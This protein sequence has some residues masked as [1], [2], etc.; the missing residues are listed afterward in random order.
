RFRATVDRYGVSS[1]VILTDGQRAVVQGTDEGFKLLD[2]TAKKP[3]PLTIGST[4]PGVIAAMGDGASAATVD[5]DLQV[6]LWN[7]ERGEVEHTLG[8]HQDDG[9][10]DTLAVSPDGALLASG[11]C[12]KVVRLWRVPP[13]G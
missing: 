6:R 7:L 1:G 13:R 5:A 10:V 12:D 9:P 3:K 4:S 11:G 8:A 2:L